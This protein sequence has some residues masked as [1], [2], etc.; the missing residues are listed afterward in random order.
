MTHAN[1]P[2]IDIIDPRGRS[3]RRVE[4]HRCEVVAS[5]ESCITQHLHDAVGRTVLTR[6][7][8]L[9]DLHQQG[10]T[11]AS[12][13]DVFSL[14]GAQLLSENNDAGWRLGLF[15]ED[16]QGCEGWDSQLSHSR[17]QHEVQRRPAATFEN[18]HGEPERCTARFSYADASADATRNRRGQLLRHD[19]TAGTLRFIDYGLAGTLLEHSRTFTEDPHWPVDWPMAENE[20]DA[21]LETEPA[22]TRI[23]CNA[24]GEPIRQTDAKGNVQTLIQTRA[25]ELKEVRLALAGQTIDT[26]LVSDIQYNAFGQI[27][28]Q[29]AGNGV[30]SC[31]MFRPEDGRLEKLKAYVPGQPALQDLNYEY[32]AAG[33]ITCLTDAA[34]PVRYHR[35]QRIEPSNRYRYDSLYRLIEASGRQLN[36]AP[37]GPQLPEFQSDVDPSQ[38]EN[39]T[40]LYRYDKAGNLEVMQHRAASA[41]RTE[42]TAI[43][44]SSNRSLPER[45]DGEL[46]DENEIAAGHDLN[47]N[48]KYLLPRQRL[49]WDLRN[50]LRQVD[51]VVREDGPDDIEFYLYDG[52]GQRLR[53]IRQAYSGTLI[54]THET[55]YL[56]GVETRTSASEILHVITVKAGR[57]TI[58]VLHFEK[59]PASDIPQDQVRYAFTDH[60]NSSTLELDESA[61]LIT[62]ELYYPYGGICWW[63]GRNKLEASYKTL[64]YSGQER[65]ATGLYYYGFRYYMPWCQRWLSA[66]RA[67][68]ADGL[69][70]YAM[71]HGNPT[72]HVDMQGLLTVGEVLG[73]A[74]ASAGRDGLSALAGGLVRYGTNFGLTQWATNASDEPDA[75]SIDP[76][77]NLALT[78]TGTVVGALAGGSMGMGAGSN[79]VSRYSNSRTAQRIGAGIGGLLGAVAGGAAPLYAY[80]GNPEA[81]NVVALS[82]ITSVPGNLTRETGQRVSAEL[83]PRVTLAPSGLAMALRT[84]AYAALLF[85]GGAIRAE[86]PPLAG[87]L[88]SATVEGLDGASITF[89]NAL[90]GGPHVAGDNRLS[91][92][93]LWEMVY[94][95]STRTAGSVSTASLTFLFDPMTRSIES[96]HLRAGAIGAMA[97]PTEARNYLGSHV[98]RGTAELFRYGSIQFT[99]DRHSPP[100]TIA[101]PPQSYHPEM[102][103]HE[104][105]PMARLGRNSVSP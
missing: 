26:V 101:S 97:T 60:Q 33:N 99:A 67:G 2:A 51:Q 53:K 50:Q 68:I 30:I 83:G 90:L 95:V 70:L 18:A 43:A 94:G 41:N 5:S 1:T 81:L 31:A 77:A 11:V 40:R 17:V 54:R 22:V 25:A 82:M 100:E 69:N 35:N 52:S 36:N 3:V 23:Q 78:V 91:V 10:R 24:A 39:Y 34:H 7:P 29:C 49:L 105:I 21:V 79:I 59:K 102:P 6:D 71:V 87:V 9:F 62:W 103:T 58:Q 46:P 57:G 56:P 89:I 15:G 42:R 65:D 44:T 4:Y 12:Q 16:R 38:L 74:G 104:G 88:I 20:R 84:P 14:T 55:R 72:G 86:L 64:R 48:R 47:G 63:A 45:S 66:D 19:D 13:I 8:R 98:Q 96:P 92:P 76:A 28:R 73:A 75:Q 61:G 27:E 37:G 85:A 80:L 93:R 32:D